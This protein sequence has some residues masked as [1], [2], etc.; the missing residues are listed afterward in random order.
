M[1]NSIIPSRK[2]MLWLWTTKTFDAAY[3]GSYIGSFHT[4]L[5]IGPIHGWTKHCC[6]H[7]FLTIDISDL[8]NQWLAIISSMTLGWPFW[9]KHRCTVVEKNVTRYSNILPNLAVPSWQCRHVTTS[10]LWHNLS[11]EDDD[12]IVKCLILN[13]S[14]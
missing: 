13:H 5:A 10:G 14:A 4:F 12:G 9:G 6:G 8:G 7:I 2:L 1:D 11:Y 3:I